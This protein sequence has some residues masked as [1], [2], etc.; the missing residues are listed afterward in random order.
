MT[1]TSVIIISIVPLFVLLFAAHFLSVAALDKNG[2]LCSDCHSMKH[3]CDSWKGSAHKAIRC[4][5]CHISGDSWHSRE[6]EVLKLLMTCA[7][8]EY[9]GKTI[10]KAKV[11]S[12]KCTDCHGTHYVVKP[13]SGKK[14]VAHPHGECISCHQGVVHKNY[15]QNLL[16]LQIK[17]QGRS[18]KVGVDFPET[19]CMS[20]KDHPHFQKGFMKTMQFCG[21]CHVMAD[22][23]MAST[24]LSLSSRGTVCENCHV[25]Y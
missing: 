2:G 14:H 24:P 17:E 9:T 10:K 4:S 6:T 20:S 7:Y 16:A 13:L 21:K 25:R 22:K 1:K 12:S 23:N 11:D 15:D 18:L 3:A 19:I 8:S 5:D